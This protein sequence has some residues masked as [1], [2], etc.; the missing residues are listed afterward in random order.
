[1]R[2]WVGRGVDGRGAQLWWR[3]PQHS[4]TLARAAAES[5][6]PAGSSRRAAAAL[7]CGGV[8]LPAVCATPI[9]L[10]L[11]EILEACNIP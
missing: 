9:S 3:R 5:L 11:L 4:R 2:K 8:I 10:V 6:E 7:E 1:M